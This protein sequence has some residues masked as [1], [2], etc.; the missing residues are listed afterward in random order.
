MVFL[1][2]CVWYPSIHLVPFNSLVYYVPL[3]PPAPSLFDLQ[4]HCCVAPPPLPPLST[5]IARAY[6]TTI[7]LLVVLFEAAHVVRQIVPISI[8]DVSLSTRR[9]QLRPG[10]SA[11]VLMITYALLHGVNAKASSYRL[12]GSSAHCEFS[13]LHC[14]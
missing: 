1:L 8:V 10:T 13:Y 5:N 6:P 12:A 2:R 9:K 3:L 4:N 11:S 7:V 14:L